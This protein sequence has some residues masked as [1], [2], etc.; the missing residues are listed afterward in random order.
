MRNLVLCAALAALASAAPADYFVYV[1]TYTGKGSKGIEAWRF[2]PAKPELTPVGTVAETENPSFLAKHPTKPLIY[3]VNE[4]AK[5]TVSA[6]RM[7]EKTGKLSF[8]NSVTSR[9]AHPCHISIDKTGRYV[10]A[11]NYSSGDVVVIR[12]EDDGRLGGITAYDKHAGSGPNK[13]RQ[14]EPHAHSIN[15]SPDNK[16]AVAADL[17]TD[18]LIVYAFDAAGGKLTRHGVTK[19]APGAG[20]RHFTFHPDGRRAYA[21][22]ELSS[23][24]T[25]YAWDGSKGTL[26]EL[27]TAPTLP[28]DYKGQNTTAEVV[29]HPSGKFVYGS[30]RGHDSLAV[31]RATER[32]APQLVE[33]VKTGGRTPRNFT[34]EPTGKFLFAA[35][36]DT[37]DIHV[38]EADAAR[39]TLKAAGQKINVSMPVC[40]RF[41]KAK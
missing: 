36:Q 39:G 32:G 23:T 37:G 18:E 11:A 24:I 30:N 19:T 29:V 15:L 17:G 6:F 40:V 4:T 22:N 33:H 41:V 3:A 9:G 16:Y 12:I 13:G 35:N 8:I 25:A 7:D 31:F 34:F 1:G 10:L 14:R 20:P 21:I 26:T 38:F 2:N 27:G 28:A 5:G